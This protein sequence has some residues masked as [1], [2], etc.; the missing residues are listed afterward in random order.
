M[1]IGLELLFGPAL[2]HVGPQEDAV[3]RHVAEIPRL[4]GRSSRGVPVVNH[5][6]GVGR[7]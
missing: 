2:G 4:V 1:G 7:W 5:G 6:A 3:V